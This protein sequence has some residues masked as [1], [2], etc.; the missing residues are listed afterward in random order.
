MTERDLYKLRFPTGEFKKP[1]SIT[2][3]HLNEWIASI[4][5]LPDSIHAVTENLNEKVLN[6]KYR[7][8]GWKIKQVVHHFADSHINSIFRFKLALTEDTPIIRPYFEDRF[9]ELND[10][11]E[12][13]DASVSILKGVHK[14]LSVLLKT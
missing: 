4:E 11:S 1:D 13:I 8:D 14:K 6:Y 7:P 5:A 3:Q 2:P 9:A 10:Y 12:P